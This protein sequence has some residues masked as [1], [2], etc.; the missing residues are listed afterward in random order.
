M[1]VSTDS[2]TQQSVKSLNSALET[3]GRVKKE[4]SHLRI[5][6]TC[7]LPVSMTPESP[8]PQLEGTTASSGEGMPNSSDGEVHTA[9]DVA[10]GAGIEMVELLLAAC[11]VQKGGLQRQIDLL[12][13][14]FKDS[15]SE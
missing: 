1:Q 12:N 7:S 8:L 13:L 9:V 15:G 4:A 11:E 6:L 14:Q 5:A 2:E 3:V 10:T